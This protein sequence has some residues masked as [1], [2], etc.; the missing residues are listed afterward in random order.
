MPLRSQD[1]HI[2]FTRRGVC[3]TYLTRLIRARRD[4]SGF[5]DGPNLEIL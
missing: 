3:E 5:S 4:E 1:P 2:R